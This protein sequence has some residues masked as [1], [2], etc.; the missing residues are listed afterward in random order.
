MVLDRHIYILRAHIRL[1]YSSRLLF[2]F[3]S[4]K[5]NTIKSIQIANSIVSGVMHKTQE[6]DREMGNILSMVPR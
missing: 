1:L 3:F 2:L 6:E 4:P 5:E